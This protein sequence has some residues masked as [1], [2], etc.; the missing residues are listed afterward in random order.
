MTFLSYNK[1]VRQTHVLHYQKRGKRTGMFRIINVLLW[2]T[3]PLLTISLKVTKGNKKTLVFVILKDTI[4]VFHDL[5]FGKW[6][7]VTLS[8]N[9]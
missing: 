2:G 8:L 9:L 6:H 5:K 7:T 3:F 1:R 4:I